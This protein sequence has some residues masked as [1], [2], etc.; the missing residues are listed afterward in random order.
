MDASTS[1]SRKNKVN[2]EQVSTVTVCKDEDDN[3]QKEFL[4][5]ID[6]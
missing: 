1:V 2:K 6:V 3:K 4:Y 5:K